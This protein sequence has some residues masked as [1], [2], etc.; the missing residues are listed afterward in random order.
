[1]ALFGKQRTVAP[2]V[3]TFSSGAGNRSDNRTNWSGMYSGGAGNMMS[4]RVGGRRWLGPAFV[5]ALILLVCV[6]F[7]GGKAMLYQQQSEETFVNRMLT[8]CNDALGQ[9]NSLSRSGGSDSSATLGRIRSSIRAAE[10][11][12]EVHNTIAGGYFIAPQT[13]TNLYAI[14]DSYTN[15]LKLGNVT[16]QDLTNLVSG[17][18]NLRTMLLELR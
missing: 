12:N 6:G 1:M 7:F 15:N 13:F 18:E 4:A 5:V 14:I 11:L 3:S 16:M 8:E 17:L 2:D 10:V 9:A